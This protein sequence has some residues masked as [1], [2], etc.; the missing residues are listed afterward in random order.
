[1]Q[2]ALGPITATAIFGAL[3]GMFDRRFILWMVFATLAGAIFASVTAFSGNILAA[4][5]AHALVNGLNLNRT[6]Q[7]F[8]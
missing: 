7:E 1:M 6:T 5:V 2:T 8:G 3:H 4:T